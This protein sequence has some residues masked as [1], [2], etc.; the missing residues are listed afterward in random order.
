VALHPD[1]LN[2]KQVFLL[3]V[4]ETPEGPQ[5]VPDEIAQGVLVRY[6]ENA[7]G[8]ADLSTGISFRVLETSV[9]S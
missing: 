1:F 6:L 3:Y 7:Q 2:N 4:H 9:M 8:R 5:D